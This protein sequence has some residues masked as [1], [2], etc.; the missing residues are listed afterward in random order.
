MAYVKYCKI[1]LTALQATI[2]VAIFIAYGN[3]LLRLHA[4]KRIYC[5]C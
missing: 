4:F 2:L 3:A 5:C 1:I